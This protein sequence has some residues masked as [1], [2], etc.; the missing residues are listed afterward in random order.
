MYPKKLLA[1]PILI[2][3]TIFVL[4]S[5]LTPKGA[6]AAS[7]EIDIATDP[8]NFLFQ[9]DNLK[10]GD[11]MPR[12]ITIK[13]QGTKNFQYTAVIGSHKSH[14]NLF[15]NLKLEV[16]ENSNLLYT[17]LLKD[18]K[19]FGSRILK[20]GTSEKLL[21]TVTMP[22]ELDNSF[23]GSSAEVEFKF[24]A[25]GRDTPPPSCEE[26]NTCPEP[27]GCE[28]TNTCPEPP[29][30]EETNTCPEPPDCEETNTCPEPPT[31][32]QT[33]TC[34]EPPSCEQTNTCPEPPTCEETNTCPEPP[35]CGETNT[36]PEPEPNPEPTPIPTP[37]P[38]PTPI[39]VPDSTEP[40]TDS[41]PIPNAGTGTNGDNKLPDTATDNYNYLLIGVFLTLSGGSILFVNNRK[42]K[43]NDE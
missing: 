40:T 33:N 32:E 9:V 31:C 26:T 5:F 20:S 23:Q 17:G 24:V 13:N 43:E 38:A 27:P 4:Y 7:S 41:N 21:F 12:E 16:K 8:E 28:E 39:P 15:E 34:P 22:Y 10:P 6:Y 18:F 35:A 37:N 14:K 2:L 30:C 25:E 29:D 19:G 1:K 42:R 11:W 3:M 36:C